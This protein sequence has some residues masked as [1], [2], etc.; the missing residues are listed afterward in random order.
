MSRGK[1]FSQ[2]GG[3]SLLDRNLAPRVEEYSRR[4]DIWDV[5]DVAEHLRATYKE[6]QRIKMGPFKLQV[7]KAVQIVQNAARSNRDDEMNLQNAEQRRLAKHRSG[8]DE[9]DEDE[10]EEDEEESVGCMYIYFEGVLLPSVSF[11]F[12][13]FIN[14]NDTVSLPLLC[15][16]VGR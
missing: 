8:D 14:L 5:D 3:S 15:S 1:G 10:D 11:L 4:A 7:A 2:R 9:G 13:N 6:Y 12:I 16:A